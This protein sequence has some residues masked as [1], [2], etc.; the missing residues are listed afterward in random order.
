MRV[1]RRKA[2]TL[3][4]A[5]IGVASL[6]A[7][8]GEMLAA[9][10]R[11]STA[12]YP[13]VL[14]VGDSLTFGSSA[15]IPNNAYGYRV[16]QALRALGVGEAMFY[17][18]HGNPGITTADAITMY[19]QMH[20]APVVDLI[21][22]ELGGNDF[23][24]DNPAA[25]FQAQYVAWLSLL[26]ESSPDATLVGLGTW[27]DPSAVNTTGAAASLYNAIIQ[28][29]I[30]TKSGAPVARYVDLGTLY[31]TTSYH[32]TSGDNYHPNDTGHA[33]IAAAIMNAVTP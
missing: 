16:V 28:D 14:I 27:H 26:R 9:R 8:T 3:A 30:T 23:G 22:V 33:A 1:S 15:S 12:S 31:L 2:L 6:T 13:R 29:A 7:L 19:Q 32:D 24:Q 25:T 18:I 17:L 4:G 21:I 20:L 10:P 11:L 5:S